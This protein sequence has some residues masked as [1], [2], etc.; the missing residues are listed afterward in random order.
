V[1]NARALRSV[2]SAARRFAAAAAAAAV[3][4]SSSS[5]DDDVE[6]LEQLLDDPPVPFCISIA[7]CRTLRPWQGQAT[8]PTRSQ[9]VSDST[10]RSSIS[11]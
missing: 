5:C 2:A 1:W 8:H 6:S 11:P 3:T 10:H 4:P 7:H 9:F